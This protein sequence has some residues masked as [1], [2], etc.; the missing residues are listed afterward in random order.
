MGMDEEQVRLAIRLRI[1]G[2][3]TDEMLVE[4]LGIDPAEVQAVRAAMRDWDRRFAE[5]WQHR[6]AIVRPRADQP[7]TP[8]QAA[9]AINRPRWL[10]VEP[11]HPERLDAN[12]PT[13]S[14]D[15]DDNIAHNF[16]ESLEASV[17]IIGAFDGVTTVR[18]EDRELI[19]GWG[20]PDLSALDAHL[21]NWWSA[22]L[23]G[24]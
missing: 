13:F 11:W 19:L 3:D 15:Y 5:E 6:E 24:E 23:L 2:R 14:V 7:H 22:R 9:D 4:F 1:A 21:R 18:H 17:A 12:P 10:I 16:E 20:T 8:E